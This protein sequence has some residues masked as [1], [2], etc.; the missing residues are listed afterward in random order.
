MEYP[1]PASLL[2]DFIFCPLSIFFHRIYAD[3]VG[4][5]F[6]STKQTD[7]TVAHE[8]VDSN[9]YS[10]RKNMLASIDAFSE[11]YGLICRID[12]YD[13]DKKKIIE[14]KKKI[15]TLYDG[16]I[17]QVYAQYFCLREMGFDVQKLQIHSMDD[18]KNYYIP[19]PTDNREMYERFKNILSEIRNFDP[20]KYIQTND[21]KCM[22]CIYEPACS[23][24]L[25]KENN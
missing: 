12:L 8:T 15:S 21:K 4:E 10:T 9:K 19:V 17:F 11:E 20:A 13:L 6:K 25:V 2:N 22:S 23:K 24:S 7:G 3:R 18:N 5:S 14:R 1:I 16:Q